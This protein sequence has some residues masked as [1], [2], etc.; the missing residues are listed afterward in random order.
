MKQF[1]RANGFVLTTHGSQPKG[2]VC[3]IDL[4]RLEGQCSCLLVLTMLPVA[5][6]S[7]RHVLRMSDPELSTTVTLHE[8]GPTNSP[9]DDTTIVLDERNRIAKVAA[10]F[11]ARA[12]KWVPMDIE[13]RRPP[14]T[15]ITFR[16]GD[17]ITDRYWLERRS[18]V[19]P[20]G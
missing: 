7:Q 3:R 15:A 8:I 10:F 1:H 6:C 13:T 14:R 16:R 9:D 17:Q 11:Q 5:G 12:D 20:I 2:R 4:F 19:L 18:I